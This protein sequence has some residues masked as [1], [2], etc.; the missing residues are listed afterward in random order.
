MF[1]KLDSAVIFFSE[2]AIQRLTD[3]GI[4]EGE[5]LAGALLELGTVCYDITDYS[6][7]DSALT[8][9]LRLSRLADPSPNVEL[10]TL[11]H[12]KGATARKLDRSD[13]AKKDT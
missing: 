7:A 1:G 10:A 4:K 8:A 13:S 2:K 9:G 11:L 3:A 5:L 6:R 12:M